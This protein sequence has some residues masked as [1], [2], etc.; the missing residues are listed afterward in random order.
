MVEQGHADKAPKINSVSV[1]RNYGRAFDLDEFRRLLEAARTGPVRFSMTGQQRYLLYLLACETG[2][3]RGELRSLTPVSIDFGNTCVFV[4][5]V[6]TKNGDDAV[7]H[8]TADIGQ[9]LREYVQG[10][11]PSVQ[12]FPIPDKSSKMIRAD[13]KATGIEVESESGKLTFHSLRHTTGSYLATQGVRPKELQEIMR[14]NIN[15]TMSR[16]T[17]LLS[18]QKQAAVNLIPRFAKPTKKEKTA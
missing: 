2:L 18:G 3:R 8:F 17:H 14:H 11:M 10:K 4:K 7:Q 5:G 16:Y 13:L 6:D 15:L 1:A 12:L 9:L